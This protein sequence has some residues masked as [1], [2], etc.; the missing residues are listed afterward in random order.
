MALTAPDDETS[1]SLS[2]LAD[3]YRSQ[4]DVLKRNKLMKSK[5]KIERKMRAKEK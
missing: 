2:D 5:K 4:A 1:R 3:A